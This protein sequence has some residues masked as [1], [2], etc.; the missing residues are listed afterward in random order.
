MYVI[1]VVTGQEEAIAGRLNGQG[2][3]TLVP[4]E[5][6]MIRSGGAWLKKEYILFSS[7]VFLDMAFNADNYYRIKKLPGVI[8]FLGSDRS[9]PS[10]LSWLEAE[11]ILQLAGK[12][13]A[14]V[15][16]SV[17]RAGEDGRLIVVDGVLGKFRNR[18]I[19]YDK[20]S[21]RV[22]VELT[23]FNEKKEVQLSVSLEED[24]QKLEGILP[25]GAE[26]VVEEKT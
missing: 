5:N 20:R 23:M 22:T 2:I 18:I 7:Y 25:D 17:V 16:P 24:L 1:Q 14:P 26:D 4:K 3:R 11:W 8:R 10:R 12:K 15:E 9:S 6:R 19:R 21:R 13:D